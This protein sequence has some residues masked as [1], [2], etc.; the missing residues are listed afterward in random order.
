MGCAQR[1]LAAAV[2]ASWGAVPAAAASRAADESPRALFRS[3]R[4]ALHRKDYA[5]A[6][7]LARRLL[8]QH[9]GSPL[10][11]EAHLLLIEALH[12]RGRPLA[13][14]RECQA[15]LDSR[16]DTRHRG[17]V[18]FYMLRA[19]KALTEATG[20]VLVFRYSRAA[21]GIDVLEKVV[22][23]SPFGQWADDAVFAI[24]EALRRKGDFAEARDQY[25]RLLRNYS[26]SKHLRLARY[27]RALCNA[28]LAGDAPYDVDPARKAAEDFDIL[29]H[30]WGKKELLTRP[31]NAIREK[32]ARADYQSGIFYFRRENLEAGV[33]YMHAVIDR[34]PKSAYATRAR[35]ILD[36]IKELRTPQREEKP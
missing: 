21:E 26:H 11:V 22:E 3:A 35:R 19:G 8:S 16:P 27:G 5:A 36:R 32:L 33:R 4:K 15:L 9:E 13:A 25:E 31:R 10:R 2:F 7:R 28:Q 20:T 18:L 30:A 17:T 34:Y 1:L 29:T 6:Q 23:R 12:E 24:A 14:A